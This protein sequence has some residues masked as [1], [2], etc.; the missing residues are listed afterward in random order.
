MEISPLQIL[1]VLFIFWPIIRKLIEG[2]K[3]QQQKTRRNP[4]GSDPW[5]RKSDEEIF[6]RG[7]REGQAAGSATRSSPGTATGSAAGGSPASG[8]YGRPQDRTAAQTTG[9][10]TAAGSPTAS[11]DKDPSDMPWEDFFGGL[12]EILSGKEPAQKHGGTHGETGTTARTSTGHPA[13]TRQTVSERQTVS[14]QQ[15]A[16]TRQAS[17]VGQSRQPSRDHD[18]FSYEGKSDSGYKDTITQEL[19]DSDNPIFT[20]LDEEPVVAVIDQRGVKKVRTMFSDPERL[21]D[22]ILIKEILDP[23]KARRGTG[24]S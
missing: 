14:Q 8:P 16:T 1:I 7:R 18:P 20:E 24:R 2:A 21:R 15:A 3:Q 17:T 6:Q 9:A 23:P 10:G 4:D 19:L 13:S 22:G 12:E 5:A 11:H